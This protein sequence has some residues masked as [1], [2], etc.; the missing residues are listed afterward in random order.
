MGVKLVAIVDSN[1]DPTDVDIVIP[2]NDDAAKALNYVIDLMG[3]AILSGK[4]KLS[5][6]EASEN[7]KEKNGKN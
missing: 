1:S 4:K 7:G 6:R 2:M 5:A 3:E